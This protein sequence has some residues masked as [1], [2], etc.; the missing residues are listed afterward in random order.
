MQ[1]KNMFVNITCL[2]LKR[3]YTTQ[4]RLHYMHTLVHCVFSPFISQYLFCISTFISSPVFLMVILYSR[5]KLFCGVLS[6]PLMDTWIISSLAVMNNNATGS[7]PLHMNFVAV[8]LL[9]SGCS[10]QWPSS[11]FL[12]SLCGRPR[13]STSFLPF[14]GCHLSFE[15][16]C[17]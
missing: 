12:L 15:F 5:I 14:G 6:C 8:H 2:T 3:K 16:V 17:L 9:F 11:N 13:Y 4:K 7:F 10:L 1:Y